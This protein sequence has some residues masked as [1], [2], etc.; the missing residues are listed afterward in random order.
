MRVMYFLHVPMPARCSGNPDA[1]AACVLN[2]RDALAERASTARERA[3]H[4]A[5]GAWCWGDVVA[6]ARTFTDIAV[7]ARTLPGGRVALRRWRAGERGLAPGVVAFVCACDAMRIYISCALFMCMCTSLVQ[8][9]PPQV[10][11]PSDLFA[12]KRAQLMWYLCGDFPAMLHCA[13]IPR[14]AAAQADRPYFHGMVVSVRAP[15]PPRGGVAVGARMRGRHTPAPRPRQAFA[16][17]Q[18][19]DAARAE[20]EA[21]RG[22][23]AAPAD[24]WSQHAMAHA[25]HASARHAEGRAFMLAHAAAWEGRC[26]FMFAHNW[27]HTALF[28]L[29][30]GASAAAAGSCRRVLCACCCYGGSWRFPVVV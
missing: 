4:A 11:W 26:P 21:A 6:A 3:Y 16:F 29:E 1:A 9:G 20:A 28:L 10:A 8:Q 22:M 7:R 25:L 30:M 23:A 24:P 14:I 27:F 13:T 18:N 19:G 12:F 17:S 15:P 2:A 5:Y